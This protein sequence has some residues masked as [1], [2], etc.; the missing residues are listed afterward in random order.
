MQPQD[1]PRK[2]DSRMMLVK[3]CRKMTVVANQRMQANSRKRT[4]NPVR[5]RF[6]AFTRALALARSGDMSI[7]SE[8]AVSAIAPSLFHE[9]SRQGADVDR[10]TSA[11]ESPAR[12]QRTYMK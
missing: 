11:T 5:T 3:N 12:T 6:R 10:Q 4:R 8:I 1:M 2:E 9:W 7:G